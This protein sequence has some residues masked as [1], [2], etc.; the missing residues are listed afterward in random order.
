MI[1]ANTNGQ[2][3]NEIRLEAGTYPLTAVNNTTDGLNGLPSVTS[4]LTI[5]GDGDD[6]T[7]L[8]RA[9]SLPFFRLVHV[10]ASGTLT[11]EGL[12]LRNGTT[13]A[14]GGGAGGIRNH[15]RLTVTHCTLI[16]NQGEE[17]GG[18]I[19]NHGVLTLTNSTLANNNAIEEGGGGLKNFGMAT[20]ANSTL[21]CN[22]GNGLHNAGGIMTV[23][24]S[25]VAHNGG[26]NVGDDTFCTSTV[27]H[28]ADDAPGGGIFN[29]SGT[30]TVI[31]STV[32]NNRSGNGGGILIANGTVSLQNTILAR[33]TMMFTGQDSDCAGSITS[34]GH[35]LI[36]NPSGCTII[37]QPTDLIGNPGLGPFTDTGEPGEGYFPLLS[38]SAAIDRGNNAACPKTDQ[39][40]EKRAGP[41]DIGAIEFPEKIVSSR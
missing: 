6:I 31:N 22:D 41:C 10:A 27:A 1:E 18:G 8:E 16:D 12:T 40:G 26:V 38:T 11:L 35:N 14:G 32:T 15:G 29:Q 7:I 17:G 5:T 13:V 4:T 39:L 23:I 2:K 25:T 30:M 24:N 3:E 28:N 19:R 20:I 36:G 37:L 34:L 33:N 9:P 21:I